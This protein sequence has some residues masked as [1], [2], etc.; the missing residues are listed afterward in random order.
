MGKLFDNDIPAG[1]GSGKKEARTLEQLKNLDGKI[2][3]AIVKVK[4]LK[5]DKA[6]LEARI[7]DLEKQ[8]SEKDAEL[9]RITDEKMDVRGQIEDLLN[10]LESIETS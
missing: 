8:L 7:K 10:E 5:E 3:E 9:T 1:V 2:V 6:K 4:S